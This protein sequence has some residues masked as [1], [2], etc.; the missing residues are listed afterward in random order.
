MLLNRR[1]GGT[2]SANIWKLARSI[3]CLPPRRSRSQE[4]ARRNTP[5]G[6]TAVG[7]SAAVVGKFASWKINRIA[8]PPSHPAGSAKLKRTKLSPECFQKAAEDG[9]KVVGCRAAI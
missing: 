8:P 1:C 2:S 7:V 6:D 4:C 5:P 3:R 9:E